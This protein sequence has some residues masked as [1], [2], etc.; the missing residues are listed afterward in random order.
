MGVESAYPSTSK[1]DSVWDCLL[2]LHLVCGWENSTTI[3]DYESHYWRI[4][5]QSCSKISSKRRQHVIMLDYYID[6]AKRKKTLT[7][8]AWS[9]LKAFCR[10]WTWVLPC[11][12]DHSHGNDHTSRWRKT[13]EGIQ[14][15]GALSQASK[16]LS[17]SSGAIWHGRTG[18]D[19]VAKVSP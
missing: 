15:Q 19:G 16:V 4:P 10:S 13:W 1:E 2:N 11:C 5:V 6:S 8:T 3:K 9:R 18:Q 17:T 14:R 7:W 12:L